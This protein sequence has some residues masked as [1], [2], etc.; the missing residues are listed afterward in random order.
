VLLACS[1]NV[2]LVTYFYL[3]HAMPTDPV[4]IAGIVFIEK[5]GYGIGTVGMMLYMMQQLSPGP[6]RT[7]HYAFATG[8]MA[9]NMML[10][11]MVSG[12][13]QAA[14]HY[15]GFFLFVLLVS[16]PPILI[17]YLAPFRALEEPAATAP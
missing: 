1:L 16:I 4:L 14:L 13:I 10:T 11:G 5:F 3:S 12:R 15:P 7:A 2:P 17:A 8:I 6:Y 9:L